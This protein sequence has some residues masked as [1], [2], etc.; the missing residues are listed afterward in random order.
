MYLMSIHEGKESYISVT[1]EEEKKISSL[2]RDKKLPAKWQFKGETVITADILG[3]TEQEVY[4]NRPPK[5]KTWDEFA[6]WGR[7]QKWYQK[8]RQQGVQDSQASG[9]S[10]PSLA[11]AS[12]SLAV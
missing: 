4:R 8:K 11:E 12:P 3:F 1:A 7:Q 5:F 10:E 9:Q 2:Y 6:A